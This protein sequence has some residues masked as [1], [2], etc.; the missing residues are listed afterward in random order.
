MAPPLAKLGLLWLCLSRVIVGLGEGF[1]PS[2]A[3][4]IMARLIPEAERSRAVSVVFGGLDVG[5]VVGLL[6]CGP[7]IARYGW[8][9]VFSVFGLLGLLW[10]AAWPLV[11]PEQLDPVMRVERERLAAEEA[12][13][14]KGADVSATKDLPVWEGLD[15]YAG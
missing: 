7:L 6:L 10:A 3:T 1:A 13:M 5:S 8:P 11:R 12:A 14:R 15:G 9:S 4:N 2:A